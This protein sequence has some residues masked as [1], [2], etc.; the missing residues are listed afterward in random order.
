MFVEVSLQVFRL[1]I[2]GESTDIDVGII[3]LLESLLT[4]HKVLCFQIRAVQNLRRFGCYGVD[5][6]LSLLGIAELDKAIA[7]AHFLAL[8]GFVADFDALDLTE[9]GEILLKL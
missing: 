9:L 3:T 6:F 5:S 8:F 4:G 1:P 7:F 2:S